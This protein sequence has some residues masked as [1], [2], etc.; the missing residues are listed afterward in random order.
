MGT[1][2]FDL[3]KDCLVEMFYEEP[4]TWDDTNTTEGIKVKRLLN[5][6]LNTIVLGENV[7]WKF[8]E[9]THYIVLSQGVKQYPMPNGYILSMVYEDE[10]LRLYYDPNYTRLYLDTY[11]QPIIYWIFNDNIEFYPNVSKGFNN[12]KIICRYLTNNC[13][14]DKYGVGKLKMEC[15]DDEPII[16]EKFRDILVYSV[17][18]DF[19]RSANDSTS[20]YYERKYR[21]AYKA[22]LSDQK[23]SDDY[24]DGFDIDSPPTTIQDVI[25]NVFHNP[26]AIG[27][28]YR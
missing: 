11:G 17:C 19:R 2:Y 15:E 1:T 10:P 25:L 22:L 9:K 12:R 20:V 21:E 6:A 23:S 14:V 16:P 18:K 8:R 24:P 3:V 5:Q 28:E 7:P 13:A 4:Q 26:R 27:G